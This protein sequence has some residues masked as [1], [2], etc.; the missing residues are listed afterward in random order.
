MGF[1]YSR[2][3]AN[4]YFAKPSR[5]SLE[6][7]L[8]DVAIQLG[9]TTLITA[10]NTQGSFMFHIN[11]AQSSLEKTA[12]M[13]RNIKISAT[14]SEAILVDA[15]TPIVDINKFYREAAQSNRINSFLT[16][17]YY[18]RISLT[19]VKPYS[20]TPTFKYYFTVND[21]SDFTQDDELFSYLTSFSHNVFVF[22]PIQLSTTRICQIID[23]ISGRYNIIICLDDIIDKAQIC[24]FIFL[25]NASYSSICSMRT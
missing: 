20:I 4:S 14:T 17:I 15:Y 22:L 5:T 25:T 13:F 23:K 12:L 21:N 19:S 2:Y 1:C 8:S 3:D 16:E 10:R 18:E 11:N 6:D 9:L 24:P 7:C